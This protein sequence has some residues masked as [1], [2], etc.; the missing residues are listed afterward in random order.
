MELLKDSNIEVLKKDLQKKVE[1]EYFKPAK[2]ILPS[3]KDEKREYFSRL[4]NVTHNFYNFEFD[5]EKIQLPITIVSFKVKELPKQSSEKT[6]YFSILRSFFNDEQVRSDLKSLF[7]LHIHTRSSSSMFVI[8]KSQ[9]VIINKTYI[10]AYDE[11]S[12]L[13]KHLPPCKDEDYPPNTFEI[14]MEDKFSISTK[15]YEKSLSSLKDHPEMRR[16]FNLYIN[17]SL[18]Q[19]GYHQ[20]DIS[21]KSEFYK[22]NDENKFNIKGSNVYFTSAFKVCVNICESGM[23]YCK[24]VHKFRMLREGNYLDYLSHL[25]DKN[26][27]MK[28][29][30]IAEIIKT[31]CV[32]KKGQAIYGTGKTWKIDDIDFDKNP[33]SKLVEMVE[34]NEN[35]KISFKEYYKRRYNLNIKDLKQPLFISKEK[36]PKSVLSEPKIYYLIPELLLIVGKLDEDR[37]LNLKVL[38]MTPND[39]FK[40]A[41]NIIKEMKFAIEKAESKNDEFL[42]FFK[43]SHLNLNQVRPNIVF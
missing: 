40:S 28:P 4:Q 6:E 11:Q 10:V 29:Q 14:I 21:K 20:A 13:I 43:N 33:D 1:V 15:G 19:L 9:E 27:K 16:F 12:K 39:S 3:S 7:M 38:Q 22:V 26:Y 17:K 23:M 31:A 30:A 18:K 35:T 25:K 36:L 5:F 8:K 37:Q 41:D 2:L 32:G 34:G 42:Q 24:A